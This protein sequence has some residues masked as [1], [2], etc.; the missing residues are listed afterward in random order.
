MNTTLGSYTLSSGSFRGNR[1]C[2]ICWPRIRSPVKPPRTSGP[3]CI[4]TIT[5]RCPRMHPHA[6]MSC[7]ITSKCTGTPGLSPKDPLRTSGH[8]CMSTITR[9]CPRTHPHSL[10]SC[11]IT[12]KCTGAPGLSPK[13]PLRTSGPSCI[14][15]ITRRCPRM[16]PHSLMSCIITSTQV[17]QAFPPKTPNVHQG[18][19]DAQECILTL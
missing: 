14:S 18:S 9:R 17:P 13:D 5:R 6:L 12:S 11:I 2:W 7:I 3:I 8:S 10:M 4:S 16:H 15:T 1:T 19:G